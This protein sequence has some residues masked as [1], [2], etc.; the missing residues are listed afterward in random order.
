MIKDFYYT[1]TEE[2]CIS[3]GFARVMIPYCE[4]MMYLY[5]ITKDCDYLV[6]DGNEMPGVVKTVG[7]EYILMRADFSDYD[8]DKD[9]KMLKIKNREYYPFGFVFDIHGKACSKMFSVIDSKYNHFD[10]N[11][12]ELFEKGR[13]VI[14]LYEIDSMTTEQCINLGMPRV[15]LGNDRAIYL[16]PDK[17]EHQLTNN[18]RC[19]TVTWLAGT[20]MTA[21]VRDSDLKIID[22]VGFTLNG[23]EYLPIG[24][25]PRDGKQL[26]TN[27]FVPVDSPFV[28]MALRRLKDNGKITI[29]KN[30]HMNKEEKHKDTIFEKLENGG[31]ES[32]ID[33]FFSLEEYDERGMK[34][35]NDNALIT[36]IKTPKEY[37][38]KSSEE[39][40]NSLHKDLCETITELIS[41]NT[42]TVSV[43]ETQVDM[44][45][46]HRCSYEKYYCNDDKSRKIMKMIDE[47]V[48]K[49]IEQIYENQNIFK[50]L[51]K[52]LVME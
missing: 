32:M 30:V 29:E 27:E 36:K 4:K 14:P 7:G 2:Q 40:I 25:L 5:L 34:S 38:D 46:T 20:V 35:E 1:I 42:T 43:F 51:I 3:L 13:I 52:I 16:I 47:L 21:I 50:G 15:D 12:Y 24:V 8:L 18:T 17:W 48:D 26:I 11:M 41:V 6:S 9:F 44:Y 49:P 45:K 33:D 10:T 37:M 28:D 31:L 23:E 39:V 19:Y 22:Y